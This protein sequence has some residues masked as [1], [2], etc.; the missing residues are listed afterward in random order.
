MVPGKREIIFSA[1]VQYNYESSQ[2]GMFL[3]QHGQIEKHSV[4]DLVNDL[5]EI[6]SNRLPVDLASIFGI[7]AKLRIIKTKYGSVIVFFGVLLSGFTIIS[8]YK[9]FYDS[10]QLI[11]DHC[12][13]LI[14]A[15]LRDKY[16]DKL[17][18]SVS[19]DHPKLDDPRELMLP[20]V[21]RHKFEFGRFNP[22]EFPEALLAA[23]NM[24]GFKQSKRDSFFW[25]LLIF[26]IV[27]LG[28]V[29]V[30]VYAAVL[31]TYFS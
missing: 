20:R 13:M 2:K 26:C 16:S 29:G 28:V 22:K 6:I 25:F 31:K 17:N 1:K 10:I 7:N 8:S 18:V 9:G 12:D 21:L 3:K 24:F 30:L 11:K 15:L 27:L 4:S 23:N 5:H 14:E 19:V